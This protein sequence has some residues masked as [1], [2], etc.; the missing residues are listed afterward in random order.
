[1]SA[2]SVPRIET[3]G[4]V[5]ALLG[6]PP[7]IKQR[8][9]RLVNWYQTVGGDDQLQP[10]ADEQPF[11]A[12]LYSVN[13]LE[14]H[15][16]VLAGLH[17]LA[18]GVA[19]DRLIPRLEDNKRIL[20]RAYDLVTAAVEKDRGI[21]PAAEWLLDNFYV[22]EEQIRTA[23]R[24][25]PPSY[26]KGLPRLSKGPVAGYPRVY[27]IA[28]ELISHVDGSVD[29]ASL[30]AFVASYQAIE[31][32]TLGELWAV[33][34][35]LR[36]GLIENLR[37][38]AVRLAASL[39]DRGLATD[40][41]ERMVSVVEQNP[42]DLILVLADM[43]RANPPLS[44]AFL[45]ELTRHLHGQ[46][47]H[48]AFA[49]SWLEHRVSEQG[50]NIAHLVKMESQAQ[51]IDQVS[52]G[53]TITS[54]RLLS[55]TDWRDFVESQSTVEQT[56][57][58][59]PS[60]VYAN[61]DF[62]TRDLYRHAAEDIAKRSQLSEN[63]VAQK[64]IGLA[65]AASAD[66]G[67]CRKA[68][69]GYY[70]AD[71]G[72]KALE[73]AAGVR[74]SPRGAFG[75]GVRRY[76]LFFYLSGI[77]L[78][79]AFITMVLLDWAALG[80]LPRWILALLSAP[81]LMC[82]AQ[83]AVSVV[84]WMVTV[85]IGPRP[86]P[87]MDFRLGIPPEHRT[88]VV[89]PTM[90][91]NGAA[92]DDLLEQLEIRYLANRDPNLH[93]ALL[94]D[95]RDAPQAVMPGDDE[96]VRQAS[97]GIESLNHKYKH[98][99]PY[100]FFLFH[101]PR[102]WNAPDRVW[103]GY[104]R[105]RGKLKEFTALL[106]GGSKDCFQ[107]IV[108]E[109]SVLPQV[110]YVITLDTDTELPRDAARELVEAMSHPLN[111]PVFDKRRR[112]VIDGYGIIQPRVGISLPSASRSWY[113][114]LFA[115]DSGLDPYTRAVSDIYQD[116]FGEGSFIGKGIYDV[117]AFHRTCACLPDN[118]ILS[119]D[120]LE[121]AYARSALLSDV[122]VYEDHPYR[123]FSD[124]SRRRRWIR[125]DWQIAWW[126]LP[127]VPGQ[128][129][130]WS[131]NPIS[132]LSRWKI[133]DNLRRSLVPPAML[134]VL[135]FA[136]L[137]PWLWLSAGATLL[138]VAVL[139]FPPLLSAAGDLVHKPRDLPWW[140]HLRA[141]VPGIVRQVG[142]IIFALALIPYDAYVSL[143]SIARTLTRVV[144]KRR[145][146]LEWT[147][148]SEAELAARTDL[149]GHFRSMWVEP[150][151]AAIVL[152]LVILA[153]RECI[154]VSAPFLGLWLASPV[155]AWWLSRPIPT[156]EPQLSEGQIVFLRKL[157]RRTW[158]YFETF[159]TPQENWLPPD[160]FQEHPA[161]NIASRTS[162]TNIGVTLLSNL[163]AYDFGY[164]SAA[165]L[166]Q[167]T[168]KTLLTM[169]RLERHRGHF[170]NWY[171]THSLEAL[172]PRYVSTI[173]SGNLA[174]HL[175]VLRSGLLELIDAKILPLR[176]FDGVQ[177]TARV[178]LDVV[179][180]LIGALEPGLDLP[181]AR[182]ALHKVERLETELRNP[183]SAL[184]ASILLLQ[185]LADWA[186]DLDQINGLDRESQTWARALERCAVDHRDDIA[187]LAPWALLPP[188]PEGLWQHG[189]R[190]D[191]LHELLGRLEDVPTLRQVAALKQSLLPL[192]DGILAGFRKA[193]CGGAVS[194]ENSD[195]S[196]WLTSLRG[197][198][199]DASRYALERIREIEAAA[200][201]CGEFSDMDFSFLFDESRDL[202][203]I[204][205]NAGDHRMDTGFYDLLASEAR[206]ASFYAISQGQ[207]GQEHWFALGRLLTT[208]R[209]APALLSW[210]GSMF[211]YL[212]PLLVMPTY[213]N[214]L[215]NQTYRAV[216]RRQIEYGKQRG[217]P[218]GISESGFN[219]WDAHLDYQYRAFGVP[220]LGLKR[221]LAED[222]VV[223][224]YATVMA[225]MVAPE[226]ACR[227]LERLTAEGRQGP[228]GF[229]EAID[230]TPS[231]L[232]L[233]V[234]SAT[235]RSFMT[236]HEGM[237]LLSLAYLLLDRPMQR[238]FQAD[239]TLQATG[240]L[241][242]ERIP[243]TTGPIFPHAVEANVTRAASAESEGTVRVLTDPSSPVPEVHLLSNGRYHVMV[244]SAGGGY[245]RWR[246]LAVT[247]WREDPT[248]DCWGT[249]CYV[250]DL[251]SGR[252][253]SIGYQPTLQ[254]SKSYEAIFAQG[255]AEFHRW[256]DDIETHTE[257]SVSPED[258]IELRRIT[259]TNRSD[260]PRTIEVTSYA[261]V[262]LAP[263]GQDLAHPAFSNLF[264]Q[265]ELVR[266]QQAILCTR[267]PRSAEERSPWMVHLMTVQGEASGEISFE[268]DRT[269]FVGRGRTLAAP[270][271]MAGGGLLSDS[272][273]SVLDPVASIRHAVRIQP[274]EKARIDLVTGVAET[275]EAAAALVDKYHDPRLADRVFD[276][277]WTH[278]NAELHHLNVV[279]AEAQIYGRL[280]G[281]V[282]YPTPRYRSSS[283][284]LARN[285]RGQSGLWG[286]GISG[287]LPI[288]LVRIRDRDKLDLVRQAVQAHAYWR[289]K[290]LEVDLVIWNEDD[291]VYRQ[292]LH[293]TIMG[294]IAAS[295]EAVMVDKPGGVF[296]RRAEQI[297]EEDRALLQAVARVVLVDDAG[298]LPEQVERRRR[299]Q[300]PMAVLKRVE[301][302]GQVQAPI[303]I[304]KPVRRQATTATAE[305]PYYDLAFFN[306]IG[307]F[308]R[309]G[310][311]YI[312]IL[313][314]GENTPAPWVN[315]IANPQFGTVV[316]ES[317][318]VYTW[319][320]N[321][322]DFRLTPWSNDPVSGGG[323]EALYIRDEET[324]RVWSPSPQPA[325]GAMAYVA[326]HGFGYSI[327]EYQEDGVASELTM[328]VA[329]DARVKFARLKIANRSGRRRRFSVT[330]YWELVLGES[331]DKTLMHVVT[332][333]DPITGAI[334]A[335]NAYN[336]EFGGWVV[337]ADTSETAR[338][339]T[340]DRT[341][342][343]GRNGTPAN[344]AA[345]NRI[346]LSGR[347][348]AGLD[349]CA[350]IQVPVDLDDGQEKE[351]VFTLGAA[352]SEEQARQIIQQTRGVSGAQRALEDVWDYWSRT[353]GVL[354]VDT[355]DPAVNFLAN[356]WL[357]YQTLSCRMWARTGFYQ[358]GGA[359]G[360]RDQ[361]QDA[362]ALLH[363]EPLMLRAHLLLAAAR[364]FHD[365]D[366][367]HWWHPPSGRGVRTHCSDDYLW[368]P[369]ATCRYVNA[370]G[371]TS[372]LEEPV[373]FLNGRPL[374]P[375]EDSY[376]DLPQVSDE[377]ET[378]YEHCVRAINN[379][380]RFG[381]HGLPLMGS[382]DWNDG[383]NLVGELGKGE[384]VWLGFF[385]YDVLTRFAEQARRRDDTAFADKCLA[386]AGRLRLHIEDTAWDGQ[387]YRRAFFDNGEPL[388]SAEN[389][390]CQIDSIPQSWSV[391]S[392]AGERGRT[393]SAMDSV[394]RRLVRR[395]AQLVQ[396]FAPP[397]DKSELNPGYI[398]GYIPGVRENGGQYTHAAIWAAMAF[399]DMGDSKRAWELFSLLNPIAHGESPEHMQ[400]YKVEPYVMAADVYAAPPHTGRGGWTW[401]TGSSG[402][403][404]RLITE[405]LLGLQLQAGILRFAPCLPP[406]W[407][408]FKINY[409]NRETFYH[410]TV[411]NAGG[412]KSVNRVLLDGAE[413]PDKTVHLIDDRNRHDVEVEVD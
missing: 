401:Y 83:F 288:V 59:D 215:L 18:T 322:H 316:S 282:I 209:G 326:R 386:E 62:A 111:R 351:I 218:W 2:A 349:P 106:R 200:D 391:L 1:M 267:R 161:L 239:L 409:R 258:D 149:R 390:E 122:E 175:L 128:D 140:M 97:E 241:L 16:K 187:H 276:L 99:G 132:G 95:L 27:S 289:M 377:V 336:L 375:E 317:G 368:L 190:L 117:D 395:D 109:C 79:T 206:L 332:E 92:T 348:G 382:G 376:Y 327:F 244:S 125:G 356:G 174:G 196:A 403:M 144:W 343:L 333:I 157:A 277:A 398:K 266:S 156:R 138:V 137:L 314:P 264:V 273:G 324:G 364:Q 387:W 201:H 120:L 393:R 380:L 394:D 60:G 164:C 168:E 87:R 229:Y 21:V 33:P 223:A 388:G 286:Y 9:E 329:T 220:G 22:I 281:S 43:A 346:R 307:G 278:S 184:G 159:V 345:L 91:L 381:V 313:R 362:M 25:F 296:L 221:G 212:M 4:K 107:E 45:A 69:V 115:A 8:L 228:Y 98:D 408:A 342:F 253:W 129:G 28:M 193:D 71:K 78:L 56:L 366:V 54:L 309:D 145:K 334:F 412:G 344:P 100:I 130:R 171:D 260:R 134:L 227:N 101:R 303:A 103:M 76:P 124:V 240:L 11:R 154:P 335:R 224:P 63:E 10:L 347:V 64:A 275:R 279:E 185:R 256:D 214:T 72:R 5:T 55:L 265:T 208:S 249:F 186:S 311:E 231:R 320:E 49:L 369:Y 271:A 163:S 410:I 104:E 51:A 396:L 255:K 402:W 81:V 384:S 216:V 86:L 383:M 372:V 247:R 116:L 235:V 165:Q 136:W 389:P 328:Y 170:Y 302:R 280:A 230:Y 205:Y 114:R 93:F 143:D 292:E 75:K 14:H 82:V 65:E 179:R 300:A 406:Q 234:G 299:V 360:F 142:Q 400:I 361:L 180:G 167:R 245:S 181:P 397:F 141:L 176:V 88:M 73:Q 274:N 108:G 197:A 191:E 323:G 284:I 182:E 169:G 407:Q 89:V 84:N 371:D 251:N 127:R 318:G 306:G 6:P 355:P 232:P 131:P 287:D 19:A 199:L 68:H 340:A 189:N 339:I 96:L 290:G 46:S 35:M 367:Q 42:S 217:V 188:P 219:A 250:R 237:S 53:N 236:H 24:H 41:A 119:H 39:R 359:Y 261:E 210:S 85:Y 112:R 146:L 413:Q 194:L 15:A 17:E 123:Y 31:T 365:G 207:L 148:S 319:A 139:V 40:W 272:E 66:L 29:A 173:D 150:T 38:V 52:I 50:L 350:A 294:L 80:G 331:R 411:R 61:M 183:P 213:E 357:I 321:S 243:K 399:A 291:S 198:I 257:I 23:R 374:R 295:S 152:A 202:L 211:E 121:G 94:T 341:E 259:I 160:N 297:A 102:R 263:A 37:R 330:A 363:A 405:S 222:L 158:G 270:A 285:R 177:D 34:I 135:V 12:E 404:Y 268:T 238:R 385:L 113:V 105:K 162:P 254:A 155:I 3:N 252:F 338:T 315:V 379:G 147:T 178:L 126:L 353:L 58:G 305:A 47:P 153:R 233:G 32:L 304:L 246:D 70:L 204:G 262:V 74:R 226:A 378:L 195:A 298:T 13:Q 310:R 225:L 358:S 7:G 118:T 354:Y 133:F 325:R 77:V 293:N 67:D 392:R 26:S 172:P 301:R 308:T 48:F 337:F 20:V 352:E 373:P 30:N 312:M 269:K 90:L 283:S 57:R 44:S 203:S 370:T 36:L 242:Q 166:L 192:L 110:R 151:V 248:R